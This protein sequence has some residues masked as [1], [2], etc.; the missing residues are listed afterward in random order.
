MSSRSISVVP[1]SDLPDRVRLARRMARLSQSK[2]AVALGVTASA[3]AQWENPEGTRPSIERLEIIAELAHVNFDWL[4]T[5]RGRAKRF[6]TAENTIA[7][8]ELS[9]F[10]QD[11]DEEVLLQ[12]FRRLP[13]RMRL[14]TLELLKAYGHRFEKKSD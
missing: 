3:V 14:L 13:S 9:A 12:E 2:L 6:K 4:A 5:G 11:L 8:V 7:A 10:A 1:G